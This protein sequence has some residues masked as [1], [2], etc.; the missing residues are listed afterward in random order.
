[1][2]SIKWY[3]LCNKVYLLRIYWLNILSFGWSRKNEFLLYAP[4]LRQPHRKKSF[5]VIS[6]IHARH[7]RTRCLAINFSGRRL[8]PTSNLMLDLWEVTG[9]AKLLIW[10]IYRSE[11]KVRHLSFLKKYRPTIDHFDIAVPTVCFGEWSGLSCFWFWFVIAHIA[12]ICTFARSLGHWDGSGERNV[13]G[14]PNSCIKCI[15]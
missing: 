3:L 10:A 11:L 15:L 4:E 5:G 13:V 12:H 1:M 7:F 9:L 6:G 14:W 2:S 8:G